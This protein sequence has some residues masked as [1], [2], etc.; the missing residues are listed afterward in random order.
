M[1]TIFIKNPRKGGIP[2]K[3]IIDMIM[4]FFIFT[5]TLFLVKLFNLLK[6]IVLQLLIIV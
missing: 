4:I 5:L 1:A 3:D 2:A 6:L